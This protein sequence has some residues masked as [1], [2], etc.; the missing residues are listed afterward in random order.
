MG[1]TLMMGSQ[2]EVVLDV[3]VSRQLV[4]LGWLREESVILF[5]TLALERCYSELEHPTVRYRV[6]FAI[7]QIGTVLKTCIVKSLR[8]NGIWEFVGIERS[9]LSIDR[10]ISRCG[11]FAP[12]PIMVACTNT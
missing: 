11:A 4:R 8:S 9:V 5:V 12:P 3:A 7:V 6:F 1:T 10:E 2:G